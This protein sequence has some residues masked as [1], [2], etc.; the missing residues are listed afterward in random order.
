MSLSMD[1]VSNPLSLLQQRPFRFLSNQARTIR[2]RCLKVLSSESSSPILSRRL[3]LSRSLPRRS[4]HHLTIARSQS[5]SLIPMLPSR[6][7][8][9]MTSCFSNMAQRFS[10]L[11][12][13]M[14]T[15][16]LLRLNWSTKLLANILLLPLWI[17]YTCS[18][19]LLIIRFQVGRSTTMM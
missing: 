14:S 13:P 15:G 10:R 11:Q 17:I 6:P 8:M 7:R 18:H 9:S 19:S 4:R 12:W 16:I 2:S 3:S 1:Q 5:R